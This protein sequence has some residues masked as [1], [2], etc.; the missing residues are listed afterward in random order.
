ML[1]D[2][3]DFGGWLNFHN[4]LGQQCMACYRL[5]CLE[6]QYV[7]I[8]VPP[9]AWT[10]QYMSCIMQADYGEVMTAVAK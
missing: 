5:L 2:A 4:I 10:P 3:I 6:W 8:K 7:S 1:H 9:A